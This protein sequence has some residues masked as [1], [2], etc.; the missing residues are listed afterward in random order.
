MGA[1]SQPASGSSLRC[2]GCRP[3]TGPRRRSTQPGD[4]RRDADDDLDAQVSARSAGDGHRIVATRGGRGARTRGAGPLSL[5]EE[6]R[7][8]ERG[9]VSRGVSAVRR[10]DCADQ[11]EGSRCHDEEDAQ[12]SQDD[13]RRGAVVPPPDAAAPHPVRRQAHG[14]DGPSCS[15]SATDVAVTSKPCARPNTLRCTVTVTLASEP[16]SFT[17]ILAATGAAR[18][19]TSR[20]AGLASPRARARAPSLAASTQRSWSIP[21]AMPPRQ[22]ARTTTTAG[23]A[24]ASSA[25]TIPADRARSTGRTD[26]APSML[27]PRCRARS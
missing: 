23:M 9:E 27:S 17:L 3:G 22:M 16:P 7:A 19:T 18:V 8:S 15:R 6:R 24:T 2:R 4:P 13:D 12:H 1:L 11:G 26:H 21:S 20:T 25:V 14:A 5:D 10:D